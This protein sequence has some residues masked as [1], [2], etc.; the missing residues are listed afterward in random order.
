MAN[1]QLD[2]VQRRAVVDRSEVVIVVQGV[3]WIA[4][5]GEGGEQAVRLVDGDRDQPRGRVD[6]SVN[7]V[8]RVVADRLGFIPIVEV[9]IGE[10]DGVTLG[11]FPTH[12]EFVAGTVL[13]V[14]VVRA[15][16][17][18]PRDVAFKNKHSRWAQRSS[19]RVEDLLAR[20]GIYIS[21]LKDFVLA[22]VAPESDEVGREVEVDRRGTWP[23]E[24]CRRSRS[25]RDLRC[26]PSTSRCPTSCCCSSCRHQVRR[27]QRGDPGHLRRIPPVSTVRAECAIEVVMN[28]S[29][30]PGRR[31]D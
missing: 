30:F 26:T 7:V 19:S 20:Q 18:I 6:G 22:C 3:G 4:E 13:K 27:P 10:L 24:S 11:E 21:R 15:Q 23:G 17:G 29:L 8:D 14:E 9:E 28:P 1:V 2:I 5:A 12:Q 16:H 31:R 25:C